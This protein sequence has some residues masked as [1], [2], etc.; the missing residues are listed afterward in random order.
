M[1]FNV[2]SK[3]LLTRLNA[4][5]KVVSSKNAYAILD[6]FLFELQSDRLVVTGSDMET[7]LTTNIEV[8]NVEGTGKFALDVKRTISSLKELPDTALTFEINDETFAVKV[9]YVNGYYDAMALN[10]DD[11]PE[12]AA[13]A[14]DVKTF[15]LPSKSIASGIGHTLFAVG[16][17]DMHPQFTGIF[18]D[19]KPDMIV[20]VASDSHKLVRYRQTNVTPNFERSFILPAKPASI[21]ANIIDHNSEDPVSITVDENSATFEN[22]DYQLSCRFIN[23]RY[24]NYNSV[25]PEDNPYTMAVDRMTLLNAVRRVAVFANVGGLVRLDL[26]PSEVVLT[27][28]DVDHSTSA[29]EVIACEYNGQPMNIGFKSADVIDVVNNIDS[30]GIYLKLLDPARAGVFVPSEQNAGDD[31]IVLQMPMMI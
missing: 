25:I 1:K 8:Q 27:A 10:G 24:P 29:E 6:N 19:I 3:L 2:Q 12:K 20:Y 11:F 13:N 18:W 9:T 28:Q 5:S 15:S 26:R 21:L 7:R 30:E 23:G 22:A 4:V 17:D 14:N 31:L 16:N